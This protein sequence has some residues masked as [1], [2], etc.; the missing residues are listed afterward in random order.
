MIPQSN[1]AGVDLASPMQSE[2]NITVDG[3]PQTDLLERTGGTA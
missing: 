2:R 1:T 3:S